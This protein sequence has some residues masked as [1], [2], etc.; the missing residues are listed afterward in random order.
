MFHISVADVVTLKIQNSHLRNQAKHR[1]KCPFPN[2]LVY[3]DCL[4]LRNEHVVR[5]NMQ[6][7]L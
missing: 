1:Y 7:G 5:A 3:K 2:V 4:K 6:K